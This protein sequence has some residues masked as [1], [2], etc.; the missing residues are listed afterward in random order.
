[1]KP[2]NNKRRKLPTCRRMAGAKYSVGQIYRIYLLLPKAYINHHAVRQP[3][4][5]KA[6]SRLPYH[7]ALV[8]WLPNASRQ[9]SRRQADSFSRECYTSVI[10]WPTADYLPAARGY[11]RPTSYLATTGPACSCLHTTA[12]HPAVPDRLTQPL[13]TDCS[14]QLSEPLATYMYTY[15]P[16]ESGGVSGGSGHAAGTRPTTTTASCC[17]VC[18]LEPCS[19]QLR[20]VCCNPNTAKI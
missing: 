13:A 14:Y 11:R 10:T 6:S 20:K 7:T 2:T 17:V 19:R 8:A 3:R 15:G 12:F 1:M 18:L 4:T 5:T 9:R 16:S